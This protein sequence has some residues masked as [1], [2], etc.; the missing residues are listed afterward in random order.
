MPD[1]RRPMIVI[2]G[3][4]KYFDDYHALRDI[5][6]EIDRGE[7]VVVLGPSGSGKSML[8][9]TIN[10]LETIEEGSI[11]IDSTQLPEEG[12]ELA[13]LRAGRARKNIVAKVPEQPDQGLDTKDNVNVDWHSTGYTEI[14]NPAE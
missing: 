12:R 4:N 7:V 2:S 5:N 10:R 6:L 9:R 13:K 11:S 1:T 3:V 8:C 14:R